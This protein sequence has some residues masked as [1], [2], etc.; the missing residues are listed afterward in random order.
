MDTNKK[1]PEII[2]SCDESSNS[3]SDSS[4]TNNEDTIAD[5]EVLLDLQK[6]IANYGKND[7]SLEQLRIMREKLNEAI[8]VIQDEQKK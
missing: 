5:N 4:K 6:I 7:V 1:A 3:E 8:K 2:K